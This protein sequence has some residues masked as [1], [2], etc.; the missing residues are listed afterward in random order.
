MR[1]PP[2]I[3]AV[4]VT[5][6][7]EGA[8]CAGTWGQRLL[9]A[10]GSGHGG[11]GIPFDAG[12]TEAPLWLRQAGSVVT[13]T[14]CDARVHLA[15]RRHPG[16]WHLEGL[17]WPRGD[18]EVVLD[19]HGR[20]PRVTAPRLELTSGIGLWSSGDLEVKLQPSGFTA[21][22]SGLR[23]E[24]EGAGAG[25]SWV[26]TARS[27]VRTRLTLRTPQGNEI[28]RLTLHAGEER[29]DLARV[30]VA[31]A[32][33][34]ARSGH[35]LKLRFG[36]GVPAVRDAR[37]GWRRPRDEAISIIERDGA[38]RL[39]GD[40]LTEGIALQAS[41]GAVGT[42]T[43]GMQ[44]GERPPTLT[45]TPEGVLRLG[46]GMPAGPG[47]GSIQRFTWTSGV[48]RA[49]GPV[50]ARPGDRPQPHG[51]TRRAAAPLASLAGR[52]D[53]SLRG[54]LQD[55]RGGPLRDGAGRGD[56]PMSFEEVGNLEYDTTLGLLG[57]YRRTGDSAFACAAMAAR[58]HQ[59]TRDRDAAATGL[60]FPHGLD[61]RSGTI[62]IGHH[63][64]EGLCLHARWS[65]DPAAI[66]T[67]DAILEAQLATLGRVDL[68]ELKPRSLG[69]GLLALVVGDEA[70]P[71]H[72][73]RREIVRWIRH[74]VKKQGAHGHL[75]LVPIGG[76]A[77]GRFV[78]TPYVEGGIILPALARAAAR[79]PSNGARA[80]V[81]RLRAALVRDA[82]R[83]D[84]ERR[85]RV[86]R[87]IEVERGSKRPLRTRGMAPGEDAAL[88]VAGLLRSGARLQGDMAGA[89][90]AVPATWSVPHRRYPGRVLSVLAHAVAVV[91]AG[92]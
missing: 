61:H 32:Q 17:W 2:A 18:E 90:R 4:L 52:V 58:D 77:R 70:K 92:P 11:R 42:L 73:G 60:F 25:A 19:L 81:R 68:D 47:E 9:L 12:L 62:E 65:G 8:C 64:I 87:R 30:Q 66:G 71:T 7:V 85:T 80:G 88:V 24:V 16:G 39:D 37:G 36:L 20:G 46:P 33:A 75:E 6:I 74:L 67:R 28:L 57:A 54:W 45:L 91:G 76:V 26:T 13:R 14:T 15:A 89:L 31:G 44:G 72:A 78:I 10:P 27:P 51:R 35:P 40:A 86:V 29:I 48:G 69:W 55:A 43:T 41:D 82:F 21:F 5:F 3:L 1:T 23:L 84:D 56:W 49:V 50:L 38:L 83:E 79:A 53:R 34:R 59:V 22:P 63:W